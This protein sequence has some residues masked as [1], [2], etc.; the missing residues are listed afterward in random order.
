VR[1]GEQQQALF[2]Q[3]ND[4]LQKH[5]RLL[6]FRRLD[7]CDDILQIT[8]FVHCRD[9]QALG[10]LVDDLKRYFPILEISFIQQDQIIAIP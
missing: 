5:V 8:Y 6:S 9:L 4:R 3:V 2:N 10:D 7:S 1:E